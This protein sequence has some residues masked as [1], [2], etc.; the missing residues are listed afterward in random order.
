MRTV[1]LAATAGLLLAAGVASGHEAKVG[2]IEIE[3]AWARPA[4]SGNGAAY[5]TLSNEGKAPDR[6]VAVSAPDVARSAELHESSTDAQGVM[7]MR[8]VE[9]GVE[10]PPGGEARL[11]P[12]GY[13]VMLV[14]LKHPLAEG[15]NF[16]L[17]LTF[18]K[19]GKV[20]VDVAVEKGA[21]G[22]AGHDHGGMDMGQ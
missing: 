11:A 21:A 20:T 10:V 6:L 18:A 5:M 16:P 9:G 13:H 19:A 17:V 14:G 22:A 7:R 8:P 2:T 15:K 1:L 4:K 3:H 12:G